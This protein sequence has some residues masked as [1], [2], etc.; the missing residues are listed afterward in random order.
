MS[1][2]IERHVVDAV[3]PE[4]LKELLAELVAFETDQGREAPAQRMLADRF[5]SMGLEVDLWEIDV[6]ALR[7]HPAFGVEV[8]HLEPLGLV[9]R[10]PGSADGDSSLIVNGHIDVVPAGD[11]S[12]WTVPPFELSE[13]DGWWL[14]R[15]ALDMKGGVCAA[16]EAARAVI[17]AGVP[18]ASDLLLQPVIGE[19]DGGLGTLAAVERGYRASAAVIPEPTE[20]EVATVQAGCL[21]F[22]LHV[23]GVGAHGCHRHEG[24]SAL[25]N[26]IEVHERLLELERFVAREGKHSLFGAPLPYPLSIGTVV[27]GE[28]SSSVPD[29]LV[30]TGR[31]GVP[32]GWSLD[33]ARQLFES[34]VDEVCR[35]NEF[36]RRNPV[37]VEWW[38]GVFE[39]AEADPQGRMVETLLDVAEETLGRRPACVGVPYGADMRLLDRHAGIPT[40]MFGAG[41]VRD[42]HGPAERVR[43]Q[44]LVA[45]ART[46]ARFYVRYC[47]VA[48]N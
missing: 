23:A 37:R 9:G 20:L 41:D 27:A 46:L 45:L 7:D 26:F 38:G 11:E 17:D 30:A 21:G 32:P 31:Y 39:S 34:A 35:A 47:G 4:R 12:Q 48:E 1:D 42:A 10:L 25:E 22:R 14:G 18:L 29:S 19:E 28:W 43:A 44:D 24:V 2:S 6:E 33:R 40:V 5:E 13:Q 16:I 15:G 3:S 36:L 8:E